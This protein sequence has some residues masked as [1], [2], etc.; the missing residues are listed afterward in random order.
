MQRS[1]EDF[2]LIGNLQTT[3]LVTKQD[4]SI[5]FFCF[6]FCDSPSVF[7]RLL[8]EERGGF[9]RIRPLSNQFKP[10]QLYLPSSNVLQ[11]KFNLEDGIMQVTDLMPVYNS[12]NETITESWVL[13]KVEIIRGCVDLEVTCQPAFNYGLEEHETTLSSNQVL[14]SPKHLNLQ[15]VQ[16]YQN[17]ERNQNCQ[18]SWT[19]SSNGATQNIQLCE[20]ESVIYLLRSA[21][22]STEASYQYLQEIITKTNQFWHQWISRSVYEGRWR[23]MVHR[24]A[25]VLKLL[26]FHPT[27][28]II[29]APTFSLPEGKTQKDALYVIR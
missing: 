24:S 29:A 1:I 12:G 5:D 14:F 28:A 4:A 19:K 6:P 10:K 21:S 17:Q 25:L 16:Y 8:D 26:T 15:L 3:A 18:M 13:R 27:G 2:G 20:T 22:D 23:E 11:T 7:A 9:F